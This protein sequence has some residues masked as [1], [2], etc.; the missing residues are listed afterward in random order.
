MRLPMVAGV[1]R[2]IWLGGR[3]VMAS[4]SSVGG[5]LGTASGAIFWFRHSY[6]RAR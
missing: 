4:D 3:W 5:G 2:P 6:D 1:G